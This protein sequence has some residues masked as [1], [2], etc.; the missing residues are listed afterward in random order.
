VQIE[1]PSAESQTGMLSTYLVILAREAQTFITTQH[2]AF[3]FPSCPT[4]KLNLVFFAIK[5][6]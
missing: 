1:L 3:L 6:V 5:K 4:P 2:S